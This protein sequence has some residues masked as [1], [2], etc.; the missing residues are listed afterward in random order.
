[1]NTMAEEYQNT[2]VVTKSTIKYYKDL[3]QGSDQ[4]REVRCGL[5]TASEMKL[6]ITP[7][8]LQYAQNEKEK[9]H[10]YEL[11][12]QR[13]NNYVEP[14]YYNDDMLRGHE[15]EL[16]AIMAYNDNYGGITECGF[17]TNDKWGFILGYSPDGLIGTDG[18]FEGKSR[19]QKFQ[20]ETIVNDAM[21]VEYSIQVQTGLL[22]SER[23][24]CEFSTYCGGMPNLILR[25]Y[26][27]ERVQEA[28]VAAATT[29]HEK[30]DAVIAQYREKLAKP[31]A[32][33]I[34]T[35]RVVEEV[36]FL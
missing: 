4:W 12:A 3:V 14:S 1:M 18:Q 13:V 32:R 24:Y 5:L 28:I 19:R 27:D 11:A 16:R 22:V 26:P 23:K 34:P 29:F 20:F 6:I 30:L 36:M 35:E 10:L 21:P 9:A 17:I 33:L 15:D 8:K 31:G 25:I 7:A 2:E